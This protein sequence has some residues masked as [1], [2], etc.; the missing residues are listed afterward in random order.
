MSSSLRKLKREIRRL[1]KRITQARDFSVYRDD[2]AGYA[3]DVL[4]V[5][6]TPRQVEILEAVLK[7]PYRVLVPSGHDV[8]K[9]FLGAVLV[10][11]WYDSRNP[12]ITLTTAPKLDQVRDLLWKEIRHLRGSRSLGGFPGPKSL[13]LE[14]SPKHLAKGVTANTQAG[15]QG[16]HEEAVLVVLDEAEGVD[17]D[18][19]EAAKSM[20]TGEGHAIVCFYNPY[21]TSSHAAQEERATT[22]EG[23]ASWTVLPMSSLDHPNIKAELQGLPP[24]IPAAV[25]LAKVNT[26]VQDWCNPIDA[27]SAKPTDLEWP[28]G[29]GKWWR[30]GP[31]MEAGALG[32]RPTSAVNSVWTNALLDFCCKR[33]LPLRGG[34]QLGCDVARYGDNNTVIHGRIGGVSL[35]HES[36]NGLSITETATRLMAC[37]CELGE[38]WGID[39]RRVP[40]AVDD[41]G[42][43]GGVSD[44]LRDARFCVIPINTSLTSL[45]TE[46]RFK[47]MRSALWCDAA[48]EAS[49]GNVSLAKLPFQVQM[50][51]RRELTGPIYWLDARGRRCV[52]AK[53]QTKERLGRSPDNADGFLLAYCSLP[54]LNEIVS[55][56]IQVPT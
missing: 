30:P 53:D 49:R 3:R 39:A 31:R 26:W 5:T 16:Q 4:R 8:G 35:R 44:I 51:L 48:D 42:V 43:G 33:P 40:I 17:R 37:A 2:P 14:S 34:L 55:G 24:P 25:R 46:D 54:L 47:D 9:T 50:D 41:C 22:R 18:Y 32:R 13:R 27:A 19:W 36:Y 52:E 6:L 12:S 10:C 38:E 29:S 7:A 1:R 15:F 45:D 28:P 20:A 11:W 56:R 21:T 23:A